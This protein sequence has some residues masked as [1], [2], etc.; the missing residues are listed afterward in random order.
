MPELPEVE[1]VV[2]DLRVPLM[3]RRITA[4]RFSGERLR[5]PWKRKWGSQLIGSTFSSIRRRGKWIIAD[6]KPSG[7]LLIHLGMTGQLTIGSADSELLNHTHV[8]FDLHRGDRQLRFR[9][10]RRFG[11][12]EYYPFLAGIEQVLEKKLGPE[13]WDLPV[14]WSDRFSNSS[15]CIKSILLDQ[16]VVAGVGN[17]YADEALFLAGIS[18]TTAGRRMSATLA[19]RLR[20][21]ILSVL[22]HAIEKRGSTIRD[23]IGGSGLQGGFQQEFRVYGRTGKPCD[24]CSVPIACCRLAGRSTHYCPACQRVT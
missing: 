10:V 17:I 13:P 23:Y 12:I 4:I 22:D 6:L 3:G 21:A 20:T 9:D 24:R 16:R 5:R 2:R 1:T 15:R 7:H 14:D 11:S 18:P 19:S 8:I